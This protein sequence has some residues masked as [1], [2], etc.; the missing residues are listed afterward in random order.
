M[1]QREPSSPEDRCRILVDLGKKI[2]EHSR[3]GD[4]I[5]AVPTCVAIAAIQCPLVAANE[6]A[7]LGDH[8]LRPTPDSVPRGSMFVKEDIVALESKTELHLVLG[9]RRHGLTAVM[10]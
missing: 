1:S 6:V 7:E 9:M 5:V 2:L 4:K 8:G 3:R 10:L